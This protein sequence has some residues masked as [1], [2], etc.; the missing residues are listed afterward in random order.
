M[1]NNPLLK[2]INLSLAFLW[3]YQGLVPKILFIN[4]DE[5]AIWQTFGFSYAQAQLAGQLSGVLECVFALL[6]LFNSSKYLHYLSIFSLVFL[7]ALVAFL[8]PDSL[9]RAFN[10][11]VMN[12]AMISLSVCYCMLRNQE[13]ASFSTQNKGSI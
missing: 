10:P 5:I 2:F 11:V 9:V 3:G 1:N 13:T 12:I 4:P 7:F 6:F 8:I